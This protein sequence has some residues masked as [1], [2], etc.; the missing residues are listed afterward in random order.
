MLARWQGVTYVHG[1]S[2]LLPVSKAS[3]QSSPLREQPVRKQV[4]CP[5]CLRS[6]S[7]SRAGL[8][9][10]ERAAVFLAWE[11]EAWQWLK[12]VSPQPC[13]LRLHSRIQSLLWEGA[14]DRRGS[15]S[16]G[17]AAVAALA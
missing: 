16:A 14:E 1:F 11:S 2:V 17:G 6:A 15:R 13:P 4:S 9:V 8:G 7:Q 3:Q 10:E 12:L 5:F